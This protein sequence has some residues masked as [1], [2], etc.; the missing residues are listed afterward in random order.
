[1]TFGEL[2]ERWQKEHQQNFCK[3]SDQKTLQGHYDQYLKKSLGNMKISDID[4]QYVYSIL[5]KAVS[6]GA[7]KATINKIRACVSRPYN[8]AINTLGYKISNPVSGII[9]NNPNNDNPEERSDDVIRFCTEDELDRF[10]MIARGSKYYNYFLQQLMTGFR[11][12]E[13]AA[14]SRKIL[15]DQEIRVTEAFTREGWS[16]LKSAAARRDFPIFPELQ[17]VIDDQILH[18]PDGCD[19]LY[20]SANGTPSLNAIRLAFDRIL[21]RTAVYD[22]N[23]SMVIPVVNFS[24]Y[25]FRHTFATHAAEILPPKTLMYLMGHKDINVTMRYYVGITSGAKDKA[26]V[27]LSELFQSKS[28]QNTGQTKTD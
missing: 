18:V 4:R 13:G 20:S 8:W 2:F 10:F 28:G 12:S 24:L 26:R 6:A 16:S 9:I 17:S 14:V 22:R 5:I 3:K 15:I 1:V 7:K 11:P 21:V 19:W 25:D 27:A 23:G